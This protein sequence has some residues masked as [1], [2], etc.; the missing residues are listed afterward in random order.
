M[1]YVQP[2]FS[3]MSNFV[4]NPDISVRNSRNFGQV[5]AFIN[6][7]HVVSADYLNTLPADAR[8]ATATIMPFQDQRTVTPFIDLGPFLNSCYVLMDGYSEIYYQ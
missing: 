6:P 3:L 1:A 8:G 2:D 4:V 5:S 7:G